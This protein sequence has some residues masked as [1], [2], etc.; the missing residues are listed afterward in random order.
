MVFSKQSTSEMASW[1]M[2]K[3]PVGWWWL[4]P[5]FL[6]FWDWC[7]QQFGTTMF[8]ADRMNPFTNS[9][10]LPII[11][12]NILVNYQ[13]QES[14]NHFNMSIGQERVCLCCARRFIHCKLH[15]LRVEIGGPPPVWL[16]SVICATKGTKIGIPR[17]SFS[18]EFSLLFF[19]WFEPLSSMCCIWS[20]GRLQTGTILW[21]QCGPEIWL[22]HTAGKQPGIKWLQ[23]ALEF[24]RDPLL[25]FEI[26]SLVAA[27]S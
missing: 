20:W 23:F 14:S 18:T 10:N 3:I 1:T 7:Q 9:R 22:L 4:Y 2:P 17:S 8:S 15:G 11:H 16:W 27:T 21:L 24:I 25:T 19:I 12:F 6:F 26:A 5:V 13:F